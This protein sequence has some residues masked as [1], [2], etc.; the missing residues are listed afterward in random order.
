MGFFDKLL[1]ESKLPPALRE[2]K[3]RESRV[4]KEQ[5]ARS[6]FGDAA[7]APRDKRFAAT[8]ALLPPLPDTFFPDLPLLA[9]GAG[10]ARTSLLPA[11]AGGPGATLVTLA[12]QGRGQAQLPPWHGALLEA[13]E[14]GA[15]GCPPLLNVLLLQGW[16]WRAAEGLVARSTA[17]A[18]HPAVAAHTHLSVHGSAMEVDHLADR[19]QVHNRML[20][21]V[22]L[23]DRGG[24]IRW[25]AH[26]EPQEGEADAMLRAAAALAAGS[27]SGRS[28][29]GA[30]G[31]GR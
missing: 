2:R 22:F 10:G 13:R 5:L 20:A 6:K 19:L 8:D 4:L 29:G 25:R 31:R 15:A 16:L 12:F 23:V 24:H 21:W 14:R 26:G 17:N 9:A 28:A 11:V 3:A 7:A 30:E 1:D 27:G 18:L